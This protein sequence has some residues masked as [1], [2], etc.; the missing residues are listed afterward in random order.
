MPG[1]LR[2]SY[3]APVVRDA[4]SGLERFQFSLLLGKRG[5]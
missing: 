2:V 5:S 3:R 4:A 1:V